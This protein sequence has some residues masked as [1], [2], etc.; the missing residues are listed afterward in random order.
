MSTKPTA[1]PEQAETEAESPDKAE[2]PSGLFPRLLIAQSAVDVVGKSGRNDFHGYDYAKAEDV[3]RASARALQRAGLVAFVRLPAD[4][5][6]VDFEKGQTS[7]GAPS[8]S[9]TVRGQLVVVNAE[10]GEEIA[11]DLYGTGV[12]TPGDKAFYKAMTGGKKYAYASA[13]QIGFGDDPED[14]TTPGG[15]ADYRA[16]AAPALPPFAEIVGADA[17]A[18]ALAAIAELLDVED[19]DDAG[20]A[21]AEE[22]LELIVGDSDAQ[23]RR[24]SVRTLLRTAVAK[25]EL[26]GDDRGEEPDEPADEPAEPDVDEPAETPAPAA[27]GE[28]P[29]AVLPD[30]EEETAKPDPE[31]LAKAPA[32]IREALEEQSGEA[33]EPENGLD[34]GPAPEQELPAAADPDA[35]L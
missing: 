16:A 7:N 31:A 3:I 24:L 6:G 15:K 21:K 23:L 9:C 8:L 4:G 1:A 22:L 18:K 33:V 2:L 17:R 12:D 14:G 27:A 10:D 5:S 32:H 29:F 25:R 26:A 19:G 13:L 35:N 20:T 30:D 11:F 28:D 34:E